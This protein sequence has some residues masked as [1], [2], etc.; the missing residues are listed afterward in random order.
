MMMMMVMMIT[1]LCDIPMAP[2]FW[3]P[4]LLRESLWFFVSLYQCLLTGR[5]RKPRV[6]KKYKT[7]K[8]K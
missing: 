4:K 1:A 2:H 6:Y 5:R 7:G 3:K 8:H